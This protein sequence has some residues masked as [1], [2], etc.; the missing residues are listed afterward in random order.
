MADHQPRLAGG[1]SADKPADDDVRALFETDAVR[2]A[3]AA[4]VGAAV[5]SLVVV[6]YKSQ[7]VR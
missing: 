4:L 1:F 2:A 6:S 7:V 5:D 3:V